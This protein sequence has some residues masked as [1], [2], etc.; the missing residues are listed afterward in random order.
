MLAVCGLLAVTLAPGQAP[1]NV[2]VF[3]VDD[4][5]W[6]DLGCQGSP[7]FETP[8]ADRL[9]PQGVRFTYGTPPPAPVNP[10]CAAT[11]YSTDRSLAPIPA[12][13][14]RLE[15]TANTLVVLPSDNGAVAEVSDNAPLGAGTGVFCE[16]GLRVQTIASRPGRARAGAT[17]DAPVVGMDLFATIAA[18]AEAEVRPGAR[19]AMRTANPDFQ[20]EAAR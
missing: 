5:G 20:P 6:R 1:P 4:L 9:A 3:L 13:L 19:T 7:V 12:M 11:A 2:V 8:A 14:D 16:A 17:V 18:A 10:V 15:H